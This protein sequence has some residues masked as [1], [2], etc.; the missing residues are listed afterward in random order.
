MFPEAYRQ[1]LRN[2][3]NENDQ[4]HVEFAR[5]EENLFDRWCSSKKIGSEY[6]KLRQLMLVEEFKRCINSDVKS[7]L[8]EK[9][10]ETLVKAARLADDYTL[11]H[12]VSFVSK[13]NSGRPFYPPAGHKPSPSLR[14]G[15]SNQNAPKPK[16]PGENK[17]HNPLSQLICNY[18]KQSG[19]VVSDCPVFKRKPEMQEGLKP[20]GLTSLTLTP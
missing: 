19:H 4:T 20:T 2:C 16:P 7:F 12:K 9:E 8:D 3:R 17:G 10:V 13:A 11:A 6:P 18:C 14:A 15:S 1:K 5:T